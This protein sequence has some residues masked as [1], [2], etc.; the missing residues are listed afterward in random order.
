[1]VS[2]T[3]SL[4]GISVSIL[5]FVVLYFVIKYAVKSALKDN[6]R[7]SDKANE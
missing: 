5:K 3:M 2:I 7:Q 6:H 4:A 1:M